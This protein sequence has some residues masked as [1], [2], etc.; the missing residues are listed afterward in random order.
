VFPA[1]LTFYVWGGAAE[2][3]VCG[4]AER[5][6]AEKALPTNRH[7]AAGITDSC[8]LD[9]RGTKRDRSCMTNELNKKLVHPFAVCMPLPTNKN[10]ISSI[11]FKTWNF[12][13]LDLHHLSLE[14][15]EIE[16]AVSYFNVLLSA[17]L[18][19]VVL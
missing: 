7:E 9:Y 19:P 17:V 12:A 11:N 5:R 1:A 2:D 8:Q 6:K 10:S 14:S 15:Y 13:L 3:S 16:A 4:R 18:Q